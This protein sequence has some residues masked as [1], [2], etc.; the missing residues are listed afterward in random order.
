VNFGKETTANAP[1]RSAG[2]TLKKAAQE[3]GPARSNTVGIPDNPAPSSAFKPG[4]RIPL[5]GRFR[6]GD[7]RP[8]VP[9]LKPNKAQRTIHCTC[10]PAPSICPSARSNVA[11]AP[12]PADNPWFATTST[13]YGARRGNRWGLYTGSSSNPRTA[14]GFLTDRPIRAGAQGRSG[15]FHTAIF[16]HET[17]VRHIPPACAFS[18]AITHPGLIRLRSG[19]MRPAG[20]P[21]TNAKPA[22]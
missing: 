17:S 18:P 13:E 11:G 19:Y 7:R 22:N 14:A 4:R 1:R 8:D 20:P 3:P 6:P 2:V 10:S 9:Q 16:L 12:R 5:R 21:G 15:T